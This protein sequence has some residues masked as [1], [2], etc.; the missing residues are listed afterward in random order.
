MLPK[1]TSETAI[2]NG[3]DLS[4]GRLG[5]FVGFR[6]RRI[7]NQLSRELASSAAEH[8]LRQGLFSALAIVSAN[9]GLSQIMLA[10]EIGLDKSAAVSVVD[11]IEKRGWAVRRRSTVDRRRHALYITDAG[12]VFLKDMFERLNTVEG[13]VLTCLSRGELHLLSEMLDRIYKNCF[14]DGTFEPGAARDRS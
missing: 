11:E 7:Q 5:D 10:R 8:N 9:P 4:L 3:D 13:D 12:E 2:E 1:D 14:R 6:L